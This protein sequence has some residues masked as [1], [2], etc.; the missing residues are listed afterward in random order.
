MFE[1]DAG[2][3]FV[4]LLPS[5]SRGAY[6]FLFNIPLMDIQ[7]FHPLSEIFRFPFTNSKPDHGE[8]PG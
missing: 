4:H 7:G 8:T 5:P 3:G 2:G 1:I 6:K